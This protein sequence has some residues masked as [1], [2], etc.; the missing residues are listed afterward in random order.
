MIS[1]FNHDRNLLFGV[2]S[3]QLGFVS[4][5]QLVTALS[6]W[7]ADANRENQQPVSEIM[8]D[9]GWTKT[10]EVELI[11]SFVQMHLEGRESTGSSWPAALIDDGDDSCETMAPWPTKD[12]NRSDLNVSYAHDRFR[13]V[14]PL[15]KGGLGQVSVALDCEL[16]ARGRT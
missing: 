4:R 6:R 10:E 12:E 15:A 2:F 3:H 13:I 7:A 5:D 8:R 11:E 9:F 16:G 14:R 1:S